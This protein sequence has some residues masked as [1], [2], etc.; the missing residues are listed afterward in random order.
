MEY[1]SKAECTGSP[2]GR[3]ISIHP[4]ESEIPAERKRQATPEIKEFYSERVN[5]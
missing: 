3:R 4:Y 1:P 2:K 5:G